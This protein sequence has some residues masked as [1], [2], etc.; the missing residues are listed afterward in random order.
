MKKRQLKEELNATRSQNSARLQEM[1]N[2]FAEIQQ[3]QK[4]KRSGELEATRINESLQKQLSEL[5]DRYIGLAERLQDKTK[6]LEFMNEAFDKR[7]DQVNEYGKIKRKLE[8]D[9]IDQATRIKHLESS[10]QSANEA[11]E[12]LRARIPDY[13]TPEYAKGEYEL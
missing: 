11:N 1:R 4:E 3:V 13:S 10:L 6:D 8:Q 2:L 12:N 7:T 5:Q 9:V